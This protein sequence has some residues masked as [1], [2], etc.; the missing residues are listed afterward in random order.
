M[1][2]E[3][4]GKI[5]EVRGLK[6]GEGIPKI[7]VPVM[8]TSVEALEKE[9][10][11]V[12]GFPADI[13][14]WRVDFMEQ[15]CDID[16]MLHCA[17]KLRKILGELPLLFT[18]RTKEEGGE[19]AIALDDYIELNKAAAASGFV[20]LVDVEMFRGNSTL[21]ADSDGRIQELIAFVHSCKKAVI[22]SYHDFYKTPATDEI[23]SRLVHMEANGAD[24]P[25]IAVMPK[26]SVD[27]GRLLLSTAQAKEKI[28]GPVITMA[29]AG[30]GSI[31]RVSG[32]FFDSA[33]TFG[34]IE[35][36]SAPGQMPVDELLQVLT[37]LHH[38]CE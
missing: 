6:I 24:I 13:V 37:I 35:K 22:G 5:V 3:V 27:V 28:S 21:G 9:A 31:S 20:D 11:K 1:Q 33:V 15:A 16:A 26:N 36:S 25:K 34:C 2:G 19:S 29:M 30:K 10:K 14:E 8:G 32:E 23:V 18:F 4:T 7:C 38:S 12:L 17:E